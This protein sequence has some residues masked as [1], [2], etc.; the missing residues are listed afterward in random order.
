[1]T[2]NQGPGG[3]HQ[4]SVMG[5]ARHPSRASLL[6]LAKACDV[7]AAFALRTIDQVCGVAQSLE[8]LLDSNGVRRATRKTIGDLVSANVARCLS[9]AVTP[10]PASRK[11]VAPTPKPRA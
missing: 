9:S 11:R 10:A 3:Y 6:A 5:E 4:T 1:M 2:F 8:S 7:D